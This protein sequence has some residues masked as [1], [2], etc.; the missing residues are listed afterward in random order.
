MTTATHTPAQTREQLLRAAFL[1]I[2]RKGFQAASLSQILGGCACTKGAL[3][4]HFGSKTE[5]GYAVVDELIAGWFDERWGHVATAEDTI[6]ALRQAIE[7]GF[8][9]MEELSL[10]LGCPLNNLAQEMSPIDEGFRKRIASVYD[11]WT[12]IVAKGLRR[13]QDAGT[14]RADIDSDKIAGF[15]VGAFEGSVGL[16]KNE[17]SMDRMMANIEVLMDYMESLRA[18]RVA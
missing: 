18:E 14:I 8:E 10:D 7:T 3:Y 1:E 9:D 12:D 16:A 13:G 4:H 17:Q 2:H 6:G 11:K 15:F 5:L